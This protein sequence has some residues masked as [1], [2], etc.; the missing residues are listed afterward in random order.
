MTHPNK[1]QSL[2]LPEC[3][4]VTPDRQ[5]LHPVNSLNEG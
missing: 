5:F 4:E 2:L 3:R 1:R